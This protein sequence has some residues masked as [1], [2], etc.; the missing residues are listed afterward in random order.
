MSKPE[1]R[2]V[3]EPEIKLAGLDDAETISGLIYDA[4]APFRSEYTDGAF[5]YTTPNAEAIR[6]RFEEGPIWI[7][8]LDG[9]AVGTVSGMPEDGR[10]YIRSMA[11]KPSTQRAGIGQKLLDALEAYARAEGFEKLFLYTTFVL[12]GAKQLYEK[13][14]FNVLRETAPEEWY[15]MGGLEMEKKLV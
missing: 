3:S 14:G 15:D 1:P 8:M 13:N 5:A 7:A 4:F 11:I 6:P 9:E 2:R 10:F 12:P